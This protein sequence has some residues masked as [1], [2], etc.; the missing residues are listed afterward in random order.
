[1]AT[2]LEIVH[3][4]LGASAALAVVVPLA[5]VVTGTGKNLALPYLTINLESGAN[6]TYTN[7]YPITKTLIRFQFWGAQGQGEQVL[8]ILESLLDNWDSDDFSNRVMICRKANEMQLEESDGVWQT[9]T[10]YT[11]TTQRK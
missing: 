10:D 11:F 2:I 8:G 7:R 3:T 5:N 6:S 4:R 9:L 1:M